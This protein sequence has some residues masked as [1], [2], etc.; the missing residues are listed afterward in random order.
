M[1]ISDLYNKTVSTK[2]LT[3]VSGTNKQTWVTNLASVSG[4]IHPVESS[5]Q[6]LGDGAFYKSFKF[7]CELDIDILIGDRII[8]G[9][10]IYTV[11]GVSR[12]D[13]GRNPHLRV[14]MVQGA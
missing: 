11:N 1:S 13:F 12:Y 4:T 6:M 3:T 9:S 10:T 2:R 5:K 14:T 7:W 8:D